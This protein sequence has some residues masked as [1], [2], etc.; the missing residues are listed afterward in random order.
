MVISFSIKNVLANQKLSR[1]KRATKNA[2][3]HELR[4]LMAAEK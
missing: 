2:A 3:A 1:T 4:P